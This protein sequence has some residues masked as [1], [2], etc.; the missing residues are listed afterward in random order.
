MDKRNSGLRSIALF[1]P[2]FNIPGSQAIFKSS[3]E[4]INFVS[5]DWEW[6]NEAELESLDGCSCWSPGSPPESEDSDSDQ[7][8]DSHS[9]LSSMPAKQMKTHRKHTLEQKRAMRRERRK[10]LRRAKA[11]AKGKS[12]SQ[13]VVGTNEAV[14]YKKMARH[15]WD[16]WQWEL[17]KRKEAIRNQDCCHTTTVSVPQLDPSLL[18]N[19]MV[20]TFT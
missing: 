6:L 15:Y 16:R 13:K 8:S 11:N 18:L 14:L 10:K 5:E 9:Q 20:V 17:Q 3:A 19:P 12:E 4:V 2:L 1:L 7:K